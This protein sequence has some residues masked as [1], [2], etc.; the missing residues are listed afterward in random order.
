MAVAIPPGI[1]PGAAAAA[2]ACWGAADPENEGVPTLW[3][4]VPI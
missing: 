1:A 3:V 2:A 4:V